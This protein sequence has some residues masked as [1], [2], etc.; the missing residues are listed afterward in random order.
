MNI[1]ANETNEEIVD[2]DLEALANAEDLPETKQEEEQ[3]PELT[4]TEQKAFDQGW[5]PQEEFSGPE[6]NWKTAKEY[7]RDGEF[8]A[9]IKEQNQKIDRMNS[10]FNTRLENSNKLH[11][12]KREQE[13]KD[14]KAAQRDAV[15]EMDTDAYDSAQ[16]KIENLESVTP[17][18]NPEQP[19]EDPAITSWRDG[20]D[21]LN[22]DDDDR[23]VF[24]VGVWNQYVNKNPSASTQQALEY[25]DGRIGKSKL[26]ATGKEINPRRNQ[27]NVT[28]NNQRPAKRQS[29]E[30]SMADLTAAETNQWNQFGSTMFTE[31]EFLKTVKDTRVK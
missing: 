23:T 25:V 8:L 1:A 14:L 20:K 7:V 9:T 21:W 13:I 31:K 22:D 11:E 27:P 28:E 30:L 6:D 4:A 16:A 29:K 17:V 19:K 15:L 5:R 3:L 12:A 18:S 24:A 26:F 10:E 2:I